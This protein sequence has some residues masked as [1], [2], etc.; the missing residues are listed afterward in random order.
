MKKKDVF[1]EARKYL[2]NRY[3][4]FEEIG[5]DTDEAVTTKW[6]LFRKYPGYL[7]DDSGPIM[8]SETHSEKDLLKFAKKHKYYNTEKCMTKLLVLNAYIGMALSLINIYFNNHELK[9]FFYGIEF[10]IFT[11]SI[12]MLIIVNH[13]MIVDKLEI[14]EMFKEL[15]EMCEQDE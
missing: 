6:K 8:T 4:L 10:V 1:I 2:G 14:D 5:L 11:V 15:K 3:H 7:H 12:P 13:N 9:L